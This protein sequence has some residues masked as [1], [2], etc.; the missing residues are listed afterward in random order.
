MMVMWRGLLSALINTFD[1]TNLV[2]HILD[3]LLFININ[4][5]RLLY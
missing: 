4:S 2:S 1:M 3:R 5:N